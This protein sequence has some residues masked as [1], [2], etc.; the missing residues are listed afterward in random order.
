MIGQLIAM[1]SFF[2]GAV[3]ELDAKIAAGPKYGVWCLKSHIVPLMKQLV[4]TCFSDQIQDV[5]RDA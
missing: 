2:Y 4:S 5:P 1:R 3:L